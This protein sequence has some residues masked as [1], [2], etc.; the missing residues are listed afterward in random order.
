MT[1]Q[2]GQSGNPAGRPKGTRSGRSQALSVIDALLK[3]AGNQDILREG[4]QKRLAK[5]PVW[6]FRRIIMPLLPKESS[7]QIEHDG[8]I[9]W[10]LLSDTPPIGAKN[11]STMPGKRD[12]VLSAPDDVSEKPC[13]LPESC[14]SAECRLPVTTDG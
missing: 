2:P 8:V 12:S 9:E 11:V 3:D 7:L 6:F 4:L 1:F 10:R 5:D 14:S 13:V